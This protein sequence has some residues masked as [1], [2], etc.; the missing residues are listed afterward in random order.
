L[1][2]AFILT[3]SISTKLKSFREERVSRIISNET[4]IELEGE[5]KIA[6]HIVPLISLNQS[7]I[8][9]IKIVKNRPEYSKPLVSSGWDSSYNFDGIVSFTGFRGGKATLNFSRMVLLKRSQLTLFYLMK[10]THFSF[11]VPSLS[12]I[13]LKDLETIFHF[14]KLFALIILSSYLLL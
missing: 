14:I 5:Y 13:C 11:Q 3:D 10:T 1:R 8:Y 4:P 6:L 2:R 7:Q 9:D 12:K